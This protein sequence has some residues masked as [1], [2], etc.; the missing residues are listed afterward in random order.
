[1]SC[2]KGHNKDVV[3]KCRFC[4]NVA[5]W[6]CWGECNFCLSCHELQKLCEKNNEPYLNRRPAADFKQ[7]E[8]KGNCDV[9][10]LFQIDEHPQNGSFEFCIYCV[11]CDKNNNL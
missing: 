6:L 7:C 5:Q 1:M 10:D 3:W 11:E 2:A 4:C 8:G 9:L